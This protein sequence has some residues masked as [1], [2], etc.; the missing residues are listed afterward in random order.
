MKF[1]KEKRILVNSSGATLAEVIVYVFLIGLILSV[2]VMAMFSLSRSYR[3]MQSSFAIDATA[4]VSFERM[5]RDIRGALSVDLVESTL[6]SSPGKLV[7]NTLN[8]TGDPMTIEFY[9]DNLSLLVEENDVLLGP[10]S[11]SSARITN[12]VFREISTGQSSAVKIEMTVE[13]G[14]GDSLREK[15]FYSTVVIRGTYA[16]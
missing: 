4:Q 6:E 2:V 16:P 12:L 9:V 7:L 14:Q 5:I 10:L 13:S 15:N 8:S 3:I 11:S 1:R